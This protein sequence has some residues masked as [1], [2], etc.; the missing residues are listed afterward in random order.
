MNADAT[1]V[2]AMQG[3]TTICVG[4]TVS[5][6][7]SIEGGV[8]P[9]TIYFTDGKGHFAFQSYDG[10]GM[11]LKPLNST[12]Y[13]LIAIKDANRCYGTALPEEVKITVDRCTN[14]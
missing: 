4:S 1:F 12:T 14:N 7:V 6:S 11:T 3:T 8:A 10:A 2:A 9:Y 13:T 5:L